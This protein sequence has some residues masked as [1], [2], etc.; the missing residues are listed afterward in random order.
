VT[1]TPTAVAWSGGKDSAFALYRLQQDPAYRVAA[2][3]TTLTE[4]Y[5]RISMHGVREELLNAQ[6]AALGLP[7]YPAWIPP[8][9][10][11]QTYE[12][13]MGRAIER[14]KGD[15]IRA[16]AFGDLFLEDIRAYREKMLAGSG[17]EPVFPVWGEDT[18]AL[19]RA[20]IEAGFRA[21]LC[22]VDP[23]SVPPEFAGREYDASLL[24]ELPPGVDPCGENG[25]FH[26]FVWNAPNFSR[27]L[28]V[29]AGERVER[30]GFW[31]ADLMLKA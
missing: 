21:T 25:E 18:A 5:G 8:R 16:I 24:A 12:A 27:P 31:F 14:M 7:V 20:V 13:A 9:A 11:N 10:D 26:T 1:G 3:L 28:P 30:D 2:L 6:A 15:G 4:G 19:A 29:T 22:C 23:R 17:V